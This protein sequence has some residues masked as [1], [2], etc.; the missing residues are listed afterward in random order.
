MKYPLAKTD[1]TTVVCLEQKSEEQK[2]G[3]LPR[4]DEKMTEPTA[5]CKEEQVGNG[6]SMRASDHHFNDADL[7]LASQKP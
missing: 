5:L 1:E 2:L 4:H 3:L 7:T 6:L